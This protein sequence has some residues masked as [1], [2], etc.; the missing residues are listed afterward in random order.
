[1]TLRFQKVDELS[2]TDHFHLQRG[3]DCWYFGEY[4]AYKDWSF[5]DTN[6]LIKNFKKKM[7]LRGTAQWPYKE[8]AI[9]RIGSLFAKVIDCNNLNGVIFVPIP[10]SKIVGDPGHDPRLVDA[11]NV[12]SSLLRTNLPICECISLI[13]NAN[14]DHESADTRLYPQDRART[15][16]LHT[17]RIPPGVRTV[18]IVDDMLTTGS[19]FK[20][21]EIVIRSILP[22]VFISGLFVARRVPEVPFDNIDIN[23]LD[24]L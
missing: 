19:H 13:Q 9:H 3:D 8:Q 20:G 24:F 4:T 12:A 14:P 23:F 16:R 15:Y 6:Q 21:V 11:L 5:S 10:P 17:D 18:A 1:M 22:D 2:L 7:S